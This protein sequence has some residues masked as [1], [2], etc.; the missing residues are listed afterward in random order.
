MSLDDEKWSMRPVPWLSGGDR[1]ETAAHTLPD[2]ISPSPARR[3]VEHQTLLD[4]A[5]EIGAL[6]AEVAHVKRS[7]SDIDSKL[8]QII[9]AANMGRGAWLVAVK[10][11]GIIATI[12]AGAAW[13]WQHVQAIFQ[14]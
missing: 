14:R 10:A 13:L 2:P 12:A 4:H 5:H 11:G 6:K 1:R 3:A 8:D 9:A 7:L